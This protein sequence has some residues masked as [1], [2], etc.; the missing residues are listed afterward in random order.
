MKLKFELCNYDP[1]TL[2][3]DCNETDVMVNMI[4]SFLMIVLKL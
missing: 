3:W 4:Q 1:I 2:D